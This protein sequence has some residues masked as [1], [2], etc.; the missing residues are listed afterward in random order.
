MN[1]V[2]AGDFKFNSINAVVIPNSDFVLRGGEFRA[3]VFL[4]ASDTTQRPKVFIG[5]YDSVRSETSNEWL[6]SMR[7]GH[8]KD[9]IPVSSNGRGIYRVPATSNGVMPWSGLIEIIGPDG[10]PIRKPFRHSYTVAEPSVA[11]SAT[12]MNVLYLGVDNPIDVSVSGVSP[13]RIAVSMQGGSISKNGK[14]GYV[15]RPTKTGGFFQEKLA[16]GAQFTAEQ[17][18]LMSSLAPG[19]QVTITDIRVRGAD[20]KERKLEPKVYRIK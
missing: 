14:G 20:G 19:S 18:Q 9:T 5:P 2:D 4:A 10:V 17:K 12:K 6:Y 13:D 15:A 8:D 1:R 11:V 16:S 3:E 7:P